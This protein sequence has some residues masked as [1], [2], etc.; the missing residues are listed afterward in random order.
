MKKDEY[1]DEQL[2][3]LHAICY[4]I[5][6]Q[7]VN[8]ENHEDAAAIRDARNQLESALRDAIANLL[9]F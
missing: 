4:R 2:S 8:E 1:I 5:I 3:A 9:P 7:S 6:A